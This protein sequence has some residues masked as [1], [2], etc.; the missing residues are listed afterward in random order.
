MAASVDG[1]VTE[2]APAECLPSLTVARG[3]IMLLKPEIIRVLQR[4]KAVCEAALARLQEKTR[5]LEKRFGWSTDTFL[6]LF[7]TGEA[8]DDQDFFRWYAL[9]E[10]IKEWETT[11]DS[12]EELLTNKELASA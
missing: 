6:R 5:P 1:L 3:K 4:E 9:A 10:A 7:N 11:C 12:L 2:P 8:G